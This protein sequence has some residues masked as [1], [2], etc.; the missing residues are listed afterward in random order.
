MERRRFGFGVAVEN[1]LFSASG[2]K[3]TGFSCRGIEIDLV[4]E[5]GSKLTR[6]KFTW[7]FGAGKN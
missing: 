3:L 5:L 6:S 7:V 2:S 4:L 1:Y